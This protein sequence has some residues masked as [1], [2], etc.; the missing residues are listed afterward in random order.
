MGL[1]LRDDEH[2][3]YG[4]YLRWPDDVRHELIDGRAY[5]MAP[6]PTLD[7]Q[8]VAGE[9]FRQLANALVGRSCRAFIAPVDVRLPIGAEADEQVETVVQPD[10][11]I[12]WDA[13]AAR[14]A[15]QDD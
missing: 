15:P 8:D 11:A 10:V 2:H 9:I 14:L 4:D 12:F 5:L 1:A 3:T 7:H 6:A 13:L